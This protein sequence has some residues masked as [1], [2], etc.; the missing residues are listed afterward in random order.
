MASKE[1]LR[2]IDNREDDKD[3]QIVDTEHRREHSHD[4]VERSGSVSSVVWNALDISEIT[5]ARLN[6]LN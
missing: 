3:D 4:I 1:F 2:K 6:Q 5:A